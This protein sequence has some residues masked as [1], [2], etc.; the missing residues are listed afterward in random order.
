MDENI[1]QVFFFKIDA[2][3]KCWNNSNKKEVNLTVIFIH[4]LLPC[5]FLPCGF[6]M[7]DF[8]R[9]FL[10]QDYFLRIAIHIM[11]IYTCIHKLHSRKLNI[12]R[13]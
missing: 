3:K 13:D 9:T 5:S 1:K 2:V 6:T 7:L 8:I 12:R 10:L 4:R 11:C